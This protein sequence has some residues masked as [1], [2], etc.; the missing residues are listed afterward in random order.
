VTDDRGPDRRSTEGAPLRVAFDE[1]SR[2]LEEEAHR[3]HSRD[4]S[5][6]QSLR[7]CA[8]IARGLGLRPEWFVVVLKRIL[9]RRPDL[10]ARLEERSTQDARWSRGDNLIS[11][12]IAEYFGAGGAA[13]DRDRQV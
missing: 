10:Q 2:C 1:L 5:V 12:A 7:E 13:G 6:R 11:W 9:N 4:E 3:A 8:I